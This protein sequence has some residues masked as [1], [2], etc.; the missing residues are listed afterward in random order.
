MRFEEQLPAYDALGAEIRPRL[1]DESD[2]VLKYLRQQLTRVLE[3]PDLA[4]ERRDSI[5][6]LLGEVEMLS[7]QAPQT[8]EAAIA[9]RAELRDLVRR[10]KPLLTSAARPRRS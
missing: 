2:E 6:R 9:V 1:P 3:V 8:P 7:R 5:S 10:M 4:A